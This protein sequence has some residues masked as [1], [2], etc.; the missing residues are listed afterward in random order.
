MQWFWKVENSN[1]NLDTFTMDGQC[2]AIYVEQR[3]RDSIGWFVV[4]LQI[5]KEHHN[6]TLLSFKQMAIRR[7]QNLLVHQTVEFH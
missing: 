4:T 1:E 6:E 7:F 3:I 2:K 5:L